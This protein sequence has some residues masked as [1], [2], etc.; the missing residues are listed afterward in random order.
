MDIDTRLAYIHKALVVFFIAACFFLM[1]IWI[2]LVIILM[3]LKTVL[4]A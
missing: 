1:M 3:F 2:Q 4:H